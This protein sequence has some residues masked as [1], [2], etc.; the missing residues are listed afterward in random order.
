MM[1]EYF[2]RL[3]IPL[4]ETSAVFRAI[5]GSIAGVFEEAVEKIRESVFSGFLQSKADLYMHAKDR[6][7]EQIRNESADVF[8]ER[9]INA[10]RFLKNSSTKNGIEDIIR[11][12]TDKRFDIREPY[13]DV[14]ILGK[15]I[16]GV[17]TVLSGEVSNHYFIVEFFEKITEEEK[18]YIEELVETFKPAHTGFRIIA[19]IEG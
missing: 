7:L 5:F 2:E 4:R 10:Y 15:G 17:T 6:G 19:I 8:Y 12:Y 11:G 1:R 13:K 3:A 9:L 18:A 16:L 14:F